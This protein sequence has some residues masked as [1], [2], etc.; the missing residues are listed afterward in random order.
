MIIPDESDLGRAEQSDNLHV[1]D[2]NLHKITWVSK[3]V[4]FTE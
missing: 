2:K 1:Y 3:I 4:K